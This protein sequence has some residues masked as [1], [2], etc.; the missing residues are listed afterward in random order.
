MKA[1]SGPRATGGQS[2]AGGANDTAKPTMPV[3]AVNDRLRR[4]NQLERRLLGEECYC[5]RGICASCV[6]LVSIREERRELESPP[7]RGG[8]A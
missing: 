1:R 8:R 7:V 2:R 6:A 5:E 4:L 3:T